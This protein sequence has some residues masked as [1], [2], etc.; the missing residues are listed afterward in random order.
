MRAHWT[1]AVNS[2]PVVASARLLIS[3]AVLVVTDGHVAPNVHG[4]VSATCARIIQLAQSLTA[5]DADPAAHFPWRCLGHR[6]VGRR[7]PPAF[8]HAGSPGRS[9]W[10]LASAS[11]PSP[12]Q[13]S[14]CVQQGARVATALMD[15]QQE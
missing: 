6:K 9:W 2:A 7:I 13:F 8:D 5:V 1:P 11:R 15:L 14:P 4:A 10:L 12:Y 3:H